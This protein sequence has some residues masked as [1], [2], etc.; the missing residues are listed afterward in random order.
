MGCNLKISRFC[1]SVF[2]FI[3]CLSGFELANFISSVSHPN[4]HCFSIDILSVHRNDELQEIF[5]NMMLS[6]SNMRTKLYIIH[7]GQLSL[8]SGSTESFAILDM[9]KTNKTIS[10]TTKENCKHQCISS[11]SKN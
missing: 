9:N 11:S 3:F 1:L 10:N 6:P 4:E 5:F 7:C 2:I 8:N